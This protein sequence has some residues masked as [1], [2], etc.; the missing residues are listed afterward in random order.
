MSNR[1]QRIVLNGQTSFWVDV[2]AGI[3]QGS[4]RGPLFCRIYIIDLF[5]HFKSTVKRLVDNTV[6]NAVKNPRRSAA[7][8]NHDL[9]P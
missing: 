8:L 7:I 9:Q 4:M 2:K 1:Y 6:F 5:E 3:P